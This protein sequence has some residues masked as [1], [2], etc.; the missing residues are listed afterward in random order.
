MQDVTLEGASHDGS[1]IFTP[2]PFRSSHVQREEHCHLQFRSGNLCEDNE[3]NKHSPQ[4]K[5]SNIFLNSKVKHNN[6]E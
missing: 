3:C 4:D 1:V 6:R 2:K 5:E